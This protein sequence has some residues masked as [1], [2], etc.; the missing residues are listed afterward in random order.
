[1]PTA[2]RL[3]SLP[4]D[5]AAFIEPMDCLLVS[6]LPDGPDWTYKVK[7]DGYRA[8]GIKTSRET[9]LY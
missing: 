1:V 9:V 6:K 2:Y 3:G 7:L 8:I 5:K 4:K